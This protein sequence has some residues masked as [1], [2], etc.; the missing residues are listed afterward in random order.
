MTGKRAPGRPRGSKS[1]FTKERE[2]KAAETIAAAGDMLRELDRPVFEG[3]AHGLLC[4]VYK[5]GSL[6]IDLRV[7]AAKAAIRF[8]KPA[9]QQ[10]AA[11]VEGN[12][13]S[14]V[15]AARAMSPDEWAAEYGVTETEAA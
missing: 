7:D 14:Y 13:T 8:E 11:K 12:V 1:K 6:A 9:L 5:D 15:V 2:A 3:D 4:L 10:V